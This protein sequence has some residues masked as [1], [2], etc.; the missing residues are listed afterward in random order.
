MYPNAEEKLVELLQSD[1]D[2]AREYALYHKLTDDPRITPIGRFLRR[3]SLDEL[4]QLIN[5]IR[6]DMN[7][8]GPRSYLPRE[9]DAMGEHAR[10]IHKV[11]PGI[12]GWWQVMGRNA[13]SFEERLQLDEYYISN[14]SIWLDIYIVIK[15][16]WVLISG[17][18]L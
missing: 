3:Y 18:G 1:A 9:S 17:K 8:I 13:T 12:T 10:I 16:G 2:A 11:R 5:V 4:P 6:G 7:L 14:W 15:T